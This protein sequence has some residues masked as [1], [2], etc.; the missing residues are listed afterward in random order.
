MYPPR[1][2]KNFAASRR[3]PLATFAALLPL[4]R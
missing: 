4:R 1:Q 3:A 2:S